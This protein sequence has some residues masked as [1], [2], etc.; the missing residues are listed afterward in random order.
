M[1]LGHYFFFCLLRY[2]FP[3]SGRG[4]EGRK[5][6]GA[7]PGEKAPGG[8]EIRTLFTASERLAAAVPPLPACGFRCGIEICLVFTTGL[9]G[10]D[11]GGGML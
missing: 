10:C 7:P 3:R 5:E 4:R 1:Q 6:N 2:H 11:K 9:V 8:I